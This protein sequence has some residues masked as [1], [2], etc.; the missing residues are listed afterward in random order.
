MGKGESKFHY[1]A[2]KLTI[3][4]GEGN[5][6][7]ISP[8][9]P[10]RHWGVLLSWEP[11]HCGT[12]MLYPLEHTGEAPEPPRPPHGS[13]PSLST[14][15]THLHQAKQTHGPSALQKNPVCPCLSS[16][17]LPF[18]GPRDPRPST[19][20]TP[21]G[22]ASGGSRRLHTSP[23]PQPRSRRLTERPEFAKIWWSQLKYF[24]TCLPR[25]GLCP[26]LT[27]EVLTNK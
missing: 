12:T 25:A 22:S 24:N 19:A 18:P 17:Q 13:P 3:A 9:S 21:S 6:N 2:K 11:L 1:E 5:R 10:K 16:E 15:K 4:P 7:H 8:Y 14:D 26:S 27:L 23:R 20:P